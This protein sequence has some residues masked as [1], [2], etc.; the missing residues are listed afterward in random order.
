MIDDRKNE[1]RAA[2]S[3]DDS[4]P[5]LILADLILRC[6]AC[7]AQLDPEDLFCSNCG[8]EA[9]QIDSP[10]EKTG[11]QHDWVTHHFTCDGCGASMSYDA[12]ARTLRCPFCGSEKLTQ[13]PDAKTLRAKSVVPFRKQHTEIIAELKQWLG[14]RFWRT[15]DLVSDSVITQIQAVYVPYWVFRA[16]ADTNWTADTSQVPWGARGDW[17][18]LTGKHQGNYRGVLV[19]AS[20]VLTPAETSAICPYN[21]AEGKPLDQAD[22]DNY[23]VEQFRVQRKYARPLARAEIEAYERDACRK[24]VPGRARN[25]RVN[26]KLTNITSEP[27]LLP[28]WILAYQYKGELYRFLANGQTGRHTGTAPVSWVKVIVA[29]IAALLGLLILLLIITAIASVS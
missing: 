7:H 9:P 25:V 28:V 10:T 17:M 26:V 19:G 5:D 23:I 13:Q 11:P 18:P 8:T 20:S 1:P 4:K 12:R 15:S 21:L 2:D 22:L 29:S 16:H 3:S 27:V 14:S 6:P 24:Q